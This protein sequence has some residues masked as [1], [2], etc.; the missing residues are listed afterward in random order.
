V[1]VGGFD[2]VDGGGNTEAASLCRY[3]AQDWRYGTVFDPAELARRLG[4]PVH[5]S[6]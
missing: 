4:A 5:W 1:A 6:R 3:C 2:W